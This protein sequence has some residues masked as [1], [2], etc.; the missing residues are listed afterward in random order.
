MNTSQLLRCFA[1]AAFALAF[2]GHAI[3]LSSTAAPVEALIYSTMPSTTKHCP[4][5]AMDGDTNSY[6]RSAYSMGDGDTFLV[7]LARAIP[8][9]SIQ[10]QTGDP[11]GQDTAEGAIVETSPDGVAFER[12][13]AVDKTGVAAAEMK[14]RLVSD[15]RI[16][17]PR[18]TGLSALVI[19]EITI[20]SSVKVEHVQAG[21]G[22]GFS[23]IS[24]APD[25]AKWAATAEKQM[26][27]FWSD[28]EA[29][30]YSDGF[31][32]P[33]MVNV[34]YRT[35]PGVTDV[36]A[37][38]GGVMTVNSKWCR[39]HDDDTGLTVHEMAHVVQAYAGYNPSWL[40]E[41]IADYIRWIKF[42]PQNYR[43]RINTQ[44]ATYHDAYRTTAT[45]LGWCELHYDSKLV[46][47][48]S[49]DVRYEAYT[50]DRFKQYCGK[51]VDALWSE[52]IAQ[53]NADPG[54]IIAPVLA[55]A[56]KPR[57]LPEVEPNMAIPV[58]ISKLFNAKGLYSDGDHF[59]SG[60][61][62]GEGSAY[63]ENLLGT[64]QTWKNVMFRLGPTGK[65]CAVSCKGQ[66]V[67]LPAGEYKSLW[68][69]GAG[70]EGSQK[71]QKLLVTYSDGT[72]Q[73][74][75]QSFSDWFEP[76]SFPGEVRAI[77]MG[78]RIIGDGNRDNRPF[79]LYG[80]GFTIAPGKSVKSLALP[81][82]PYVKLF[83]IT[84]AK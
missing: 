5:M 36:A 17:L 76:K 2:A 12:A 57:T 81:Y 29:M 16:R 37:T 65:D 79:Y 22:R 33:N 47:K 64:A 31:I 41:G 40:V 8:V 32:P 38:G 62:D 69:L 11:E 50:K 15:L 27:S 82:N 73:E 21:P 59:S 51:D 77:K 71:S 78:Y 54:H 84:V 6:F 45:F 46:T 43:P 53:Y 14:S 49:R 19:R 18:G 80:Y 67:A 1:A 74:V 66:V 3:A 30:L 55:E 4:A 39:A 52:F 13:G 70:I 23:D 10:V 42:E 7:R 35:G 56:D 9:E 68:L 25:L 61:L 28:T 34:I 26:E 83:A 72:A 44:T 58:D 63:S 20:R 75:T 60:G 24:Q 48:L